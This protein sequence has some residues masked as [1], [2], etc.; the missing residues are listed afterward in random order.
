MRRYSGAVFQGASGLGSPAGFFSPSKFTPSR[1][2]LGQAPPRELVEGVDVTRGQC[3]CEFMNDNELGQGCAVPSA[4]AEGGS[5]EYG[6]DGGSSGLSKNTLLTIAAVGG[7]GV[8]A[9]LIL[10]IL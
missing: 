3:L 5:A 7:A 2:V 8:A 1:P 9:L 4:G 10:G 6:T